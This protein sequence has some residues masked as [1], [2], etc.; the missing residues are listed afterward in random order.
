M[1]I[2]QY[3]KKSGR[4]GMSKQAWLK[5]RQNLNPEVF[6]YLNDHYMRMFYEDGGEKL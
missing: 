4:E 6:R 5:A 2:R 1:E 3:E